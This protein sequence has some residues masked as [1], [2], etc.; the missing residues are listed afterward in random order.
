MDEMVHTEL[1][2]EE[3][4]ESVDPQLI[5]Q[6]FETDLGRRMVQAASI[7]REIPFSLSFPAREIY[8][9]WQGE[10]EP[11]LIQGIVDCVFEDEKG[12]VLLDYKTDGITGRFKGGF[13]EAKP[14]LKDR[15]Q[16]QID[17][18]TRAL[19]QILKREVNERYLFFFDG[20]HS[21]KI[22]K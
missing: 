13:T 14:V 12:L 16:V 9:D 7:R 22:E 3:Q 15:Y 21:I 6:F 5:V 19:E 1:L 11:V 2:T 18:Y 17:I 4:R 8:P 20:A 10:D